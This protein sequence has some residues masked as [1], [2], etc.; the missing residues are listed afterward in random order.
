M[1]LQSHLPFLVV[2]SGAVVNGSVTG[3]FKEVVDAVFFL[4]VRFSFEYLFSVSRKALYWDLI[5][6]LFPAPLYPS[7][8]VDMPGFDVLKRVRRMPVSLTTKSFFFELHTSTLPVKTWLHEKG[9]FVPWTVN[10][11]LCNTPET[12][13]HC[14]IFCTDAF[15]FWDV[16]QRTLKKDLFIT[17]YTIRFLPVPPGEPA[18]YDLFLILG[19]HSLWRCRMIDR[20]ADPP[21]STKSIFLEMI[22]HLKAVYDH[23]EERPERLPVLNR[24]QALPDF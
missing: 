10:C 21:R 2:A 12:I 11:R 15:L 6:T 9:V 1:F 17:P 14:V 7:V 3:F 19:L 23:L 8:Y 24:C 20:N 4:K 16:R 22:S 5:D 13:E 18:P